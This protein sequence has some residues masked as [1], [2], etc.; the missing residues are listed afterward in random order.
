MVLHAILVWTLSR[1]IGTRYLTITNPEIDP[2]SC[3]CQL[4]NIQVAIPDQAQKNR[5]F[6]K[7]LTFT[8]GFK[9]NTGV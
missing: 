7:A 8:T 3:G 5:T 4:F 2:P 6:I 9:E 1:N